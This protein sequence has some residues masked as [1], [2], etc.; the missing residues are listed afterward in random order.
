MATHDVNSGNGTVHLVFFD[1]IG[2][3]FGFGI[4][5]FEG[6]NDTD[7]WAGRFHDELGS[8]PNEL[9]STKFGQI[10]HKWFL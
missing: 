10:H 1:N 7:G 8:L 5:P 3:I 4:S 6:P 2:D 9:D